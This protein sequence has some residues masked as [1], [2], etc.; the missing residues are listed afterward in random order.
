ME[1][2]TID[3]ILNRA[4]P[5]DLEKYFPD[6]WS[7]TVVDIL[8]RPMMPLEDKLSLVCREEWIDAK[9]LR[10]FAIWCA[11]QVERWFHDDSAK[12][13]IEVAENFI[14][15]KASREE[16]VAARNESSETRALTWD[17]V[18][19]AVMRVLRDKVRMESHA[20]YKIIAK[21]EECEAMRSAAWDA[22]RDA[23]FEAAMES[24]KTVA[25]DEAIVATREAT[26]Y[27]VRSAVWDAAM[28]VEEGATGAAVMLTPCEAAI[29]AARATVIEWARYAAM[30]AAWEAAIALA[31]D[32][33]WLAAKEWVGKLTW[34]AAWELTWEPAWKAGWKSARDAQCAK[35][36]EMVEEA[37]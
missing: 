35:L 30:R 11:K 32:T 1:I 34:K 17:A 27:V 31:R 13:A 4:I 7:G 24:V 12:R 23:A 18:D 14:Q 2:F 36:I 9:T 28:K 8:K 29:E 26:R 15:G 19:D 10:R 25:R 20:A 3:D 5:N 37:A 16:L 22:I 6:R 21:N 33:V